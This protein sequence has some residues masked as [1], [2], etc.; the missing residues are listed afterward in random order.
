MD[1][2]Q[3]HSQAHTDILA[4]TQKPVVSLHLAAYPIY[5]VL[6]ALHLRFALLLKNLQY[7]GPELWDADTVPGLMKEL[8]AVLVRQ[9]ET[10]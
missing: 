2:R 8:G 6:I 7:M 10:T 3:V 4:Q 1:Y 9:D 5:P